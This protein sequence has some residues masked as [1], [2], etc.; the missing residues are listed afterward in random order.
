MEQQ[1]QGSET[2]HRSSVTGHGTPVTEVDSSRVSSPSPSPLSH[3]DGFG[4][5]RDVACSST[6]APMV[7]R[8]AWRSENFHV[9]WPTVDRGEGCIPLHKKQR[10]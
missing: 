1:P 6:A 2:N 9:P 7:E 5:F 8:L 4:L 3:P 10:N